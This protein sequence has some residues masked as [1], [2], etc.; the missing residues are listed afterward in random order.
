MPK[1]PADFQIGDWVIY[2]PEPEKKFEIIAIAGM[3]YQLGAGEFQSNVS[4]PAGFDFLL[5]RGGDFKGFE[6]YKS[7]FR[8]EIQATPVLK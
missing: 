8:R 3:P 2:L 6:P 4:V 7:A 1:T 5:R